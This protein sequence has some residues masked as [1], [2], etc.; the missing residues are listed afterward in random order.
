MSEPTQSDS[1]LNELRSFTQ[2][3]SHNIDVLRN[4]FEQF[5]IQQ[6][7][8]A[9]RDEVQELTSITHDAFDSVSG[10]SNHFRK[11]R[12]PYDTSEVESTN[13]RNDRLSAARNSLFEAIGEAK[14]KNYK[15]RLSYLLENADI[16]IDDP[17]ENEETHFRLYNNFMRT[18]AITMREIADGPS[19]T[20]LFYDRYK[21][22]HNGVF[23]VPFSGEGDVHGQTAP[24]LFRQRN[25]STRTQERSRTTPQTKKKAPRSRSRAT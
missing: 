18:Y 19:K 15:E 3:T 12:F 14:L 6:S 7:G 17:H 25:R 11:P 4:E 16:L 10:P 9:T 21:M 20:Q 22:E 5:R 23:G 8:F 24:N 13:S 2:Q 1:L